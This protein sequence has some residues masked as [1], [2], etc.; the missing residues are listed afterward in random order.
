MNDRDGT[1]RFK[2]VLDVEKPSCTVVSFREVVDVSSDDESAENDDLN[3]FQPAPS[4]TNNTKQAVAP[5]YISLVEGILNEYH[6]EH[7]QTRVQKGRIRKPKG[8]KSINKNESIAQRVVGPRPLVSAEEN[9]QGRSLVPVSNSQDRASRS[10]YQPHVPIPQ[11]RE[12]RS[13]PGQ[14]PQYDL[15]R[16]REGPYTYKSLHAKVVR[17]SQANTYLRGPDLPCLPFVLQIT[18]LRSLQSALESMCYRFVQKWLPRILVANEWDCPENI[19]LNLWWKAIDEC[20]I[21]IEAIGPQP[22]RPLGTIFRRVPNIRHFAV[23]RLPDISIANIQDMITDALDIAKV[24]RDDFLVPKLKLWREK[25]EY[26]SKL[27]RDSRS[28]F[29]VARKI[30]SI[31]ALKEDN[32]KS[33]EKLRKDIEALKNEILVKEQQISSLQGEYNT[34][35]TK[36]NEIINRARI[37]DRPIIQEAEPLGNFKWL[38]ECF[39]L[40]LDRDAPNLK[41]AENLSGEV[42]RIQ[43]I[44]LR[45]FAPGMPSNS[46]VANMNVSSRLNLGAVTGGN[47][48]AINPNPPRRPDINSTPHVG[49]SRTGSKPAIIPIPGA[50]NMLYSHV[51]NNLVGIPGLGRRAVSGPVLSSRG[52]Q[53]IPA[54]AV[55]IDLTDQDDDV[56]SE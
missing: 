49:L 39:T 37:G 54:T 52:R 28:N 21:P 32:I 42:I 24:F 3:S 27:I 55:I 47:N 10:V 50:N 41:P 7:G 16:V 18:I 48:L 11:S 6:Q 17:H 26:F 9:G 22:S 14:I 45:R 25:L 34:H 30:D 5:D 2:S 4:C 33:Q 53:P 51:P 20:Q 8:P 40:N 38:E 23:H 31:H 46:G 1:Q 36:E 35:L 56:M 43:N 29:Y 44:G 12:V 13:G 19:E 15:R